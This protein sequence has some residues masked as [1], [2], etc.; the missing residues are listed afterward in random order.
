MP[1][2]GVGSS[3]GAGIPIAV[4]PETIFIVCVASTVLKSSEIK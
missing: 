4:E 1:P 3:V 2:T